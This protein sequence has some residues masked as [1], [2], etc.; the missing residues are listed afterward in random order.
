MLREEMAALCSF[1]LWISVMNTLL[2]NQIN[3]SQLAKY[4]SIN[5]DILCYPQKSQGK[6]ASQGII[7]H[8]L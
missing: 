5:Y 2:T 6:K 8:V 7:I 1:L 3:I 4:T